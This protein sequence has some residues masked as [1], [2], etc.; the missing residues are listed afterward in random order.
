MHYFIALVVDPDTVG[1][2]DGAGKYAAGENLWAYQG[3]S[4]VSPGW[5]V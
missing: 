2:E 1:N 3:P 4:K 5:Q